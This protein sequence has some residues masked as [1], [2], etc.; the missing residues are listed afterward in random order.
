ML[1]NFSQFPCEEGNFIFIVVGID[2][3]AP[4]ETAD[5]KLQL[6]YFALFLQ[7]E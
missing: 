1:D 7:Q 2:D 3:S 5:V 6:R 4:T